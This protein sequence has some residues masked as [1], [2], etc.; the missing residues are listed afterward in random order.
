MPNSDLYW[1][2]CRNYKCICLITDSSAAERHQEGKSL[3]NIFYFT[4]RKSR[5]GL[6]HFVHCFVVEISESLY[7]LDNNSDVINKP[8]W[9]WLNSSWVSHLHPDVRKGEQL[10]LSG[11]LRKA[12]HP[13]CF[14]NQKE[15]NLLQPDMQ[16]KH[17]LNVSRFNPGNMQQTRN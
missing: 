12:V 13:H 2:M 16:V 8:E 17:S 5:T 7:N 1:L 6:I 14:A 9:G 11:I 4:H 3:L 10:K 15:V